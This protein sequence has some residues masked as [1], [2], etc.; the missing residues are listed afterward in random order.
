[1]T[2]ENKLA[3]VVGFGLLLFVG[4]LV[5]D[6]FSTAQRQEN[7]N[8]VTADRT[9]ERVSRPISIAAMPVAGVNAIQPAE[10]MPGNTPNDV[11][12]TSNENTAA[13][14]ARTPNSD[15][16]PIPNLPNP[17]PETPVTTVDK[18]KATKVQE[19]EPGV[20]LHPIAEGETLYSICAKTYGDG[21]LWKELAEYNKKA[22]PNPAQLRKGVTLRLPPAEKL[23]H[24]SAVASTTKGARVSATPSEQENAALH[25][26]SASGSKASPNVQL[27]AASDLASVDMNPPVIGERT[28]VVE[29]EPKSLKSPAKSS[30]VEPDPKSTK[31]AAKTAAPKSASKSA[32]SSSGGDTYVVQKGDTLASISRKKLGK[33]G[34]WQDIVA[35]NESTLSNP[36]ALSPGMT[37][38]LPK[39]N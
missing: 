32:A 37:I 24:G 14:D 21:T 15:V 22:L 25:S 20:Q 30:V 28:S 11:R 19:S 27:L 12:R 38:K 8:L 9:R 5:S 4:I 3:M 36:A 29:V 2:R 6:H 1:M 39:T 26:N 33:N 35:A 13:P 18:S 23:R 10:V 16:R 34:K 7:A 31:T 17:A